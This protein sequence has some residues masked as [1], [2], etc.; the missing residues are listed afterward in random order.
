[1]ATA[2]CTRSSPTAYCR[3]R[4]S[5]KAG[6]EPGDD[7]P[8][9]SRARQYAVG[10]LRVQGAVANCRKSAQEVQGVAEAFED[11]RKQL[12]NN[13]IDTEELKNRL[14]GGIAEPLRRIA[15]PMFPELERRLES[16]QAGLD[17]V[18]TGPALRDKAQ[19]QAN[20]ILLAMRKVLDRMIEL[21]DFNEAV[22]LLRNI[23][24]MQEQLHD[25]T[26]QRHKQRVRDLLKD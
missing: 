10:L 2:P 8:A 26:Q 9:D 15:N 3:A 4:E 19:Q 21:E 17:D 1:L 6:S 23:I 25:Q 7:E 18:K 11:I 22:E 16:L 24:K 12:I 20:E 5:A 14:Q 13:R